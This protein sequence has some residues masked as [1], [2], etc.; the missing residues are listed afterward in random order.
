MF[1]QVNFCVEMQ[2]L[3]A[4]KSYVDTTKL[5]QRPHFIKRGE[6]KRLHGSYKTWNVPNT[7]VSKDGEICLEL[8]PKA[9]KL[10]PSSLAFLPSSLLPTLSRQH[11]AAA[12]SELTGAGRWVQGAALPSLANWQEF[13]CFSASQ[14]GIPQSKESLCSDWKNERKAAQLLC[15]VWWSPT[16]LALQLLWVSWRRRKELPENNN[17][18]SKEGKTGT[19]VIR[20]SCIPTENTNIM[21]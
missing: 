1:Y 2:C 18:E 7:T 15:T 9:A 10:T 6:K 3:S 19:V 4:F 11:Q 13:I 16:L 17:T 20:R 8:N 12:G 21:F 5:I 14:S